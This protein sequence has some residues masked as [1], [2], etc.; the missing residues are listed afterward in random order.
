ML[1]STNE[2]SWVSLKINLQFLLTGSVLSESNWQIQSLWW[3][4]YLDIKSQFLSYNNSGKLFFSKI[5]M[6]MIE[7]IISIIY[8]YIIHSLQKTVIGIVTRQHN[9]TSSWVGHKNNFEH[10]PTPPN[11]QLCWIFL[12]LF[13]IRTISPN[14]PLKK[15]NIICE[16]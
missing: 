15:N 10:H 9:T 12:H 2:F 1:I 14:N 3:L 16:C 4:Y 13:C 8:L 11:K 7:F 5:N 6:L